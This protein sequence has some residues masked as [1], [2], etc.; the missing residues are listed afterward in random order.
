MKKLHKLIANS[1]HSIITKSLTNETTQREISIDFRTPREVAEEKGVPFI[2]ERHYSPKVP[3]VPINKD[4]EQVK[5]YEVLKHFHLELYETNTTALNLLERAN[6]LMSS[7]PDS[8]SLDEWKKEYQI[9][10]LSR[11]GKLEI[12]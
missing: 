4:D 11:I 6:I 8:Q 2:I 10:L 5:K 9:Y 7:L 12:R 1:N 3:L